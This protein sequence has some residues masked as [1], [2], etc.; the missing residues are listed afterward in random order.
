MSN[1]LA[2]SYTIGFTNQVLFYRYEQTDVEARKAPSFY[3][4]SNGLLVSLRIVGR[5]KQAFY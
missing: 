4:M 2:L 5:E 3:H 1:V